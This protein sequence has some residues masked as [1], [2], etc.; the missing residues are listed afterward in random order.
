M[1]QIAGFGR[2]GFE[3][4]LSRQWCIVTDFVENNGRKDSSHLH[5]KLV[6]K[7][8][9][10]RSTPLCKGAA[11]QV[12]MI[13]RGNNFFMG[14][15]KRRKNA[16]DESLIVKGTIPDSTTGTDSRQGAASCQCRA[17][18]T[19]TTQKHNGRRSR[20]CRQGAMRKLP[21]HSDRGKG[22]GDQPVLLSGMASA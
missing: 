9:E 7:D 19:I 15:T 20:C 8:N 11:C 1:Q 5:S 10:Y 6:D 2:K 12:D 14:V 22:G 21:L 16:F 13:S 18:L 3:M 4:H 17:P